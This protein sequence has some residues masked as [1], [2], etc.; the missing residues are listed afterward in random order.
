M[1]RK[2][3]QIGDP[4]LLKKSKD[5]DPKDLL[6][7]E[8]QDLIKD[9]LDTC[10]SEKEGTAG[11]SAVQIG[12]LKRVF[13]ARRVDLEMDADSDDPIWEVMINPEIFV[14]NEKPVEMWEGC[15]SIGKGDE[16]LFGPVSRPKQIEVKYLDEKGNSKSLVAKDY[17]AHVVLHEYD[18]L[19]GTLFLSYIDNPENIWKS[20]E[21]D[22]YLDE[23]DHYPPVL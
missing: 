10:D 20:G 1:V 23:H 22:G 13:I 5:I 8:T 7:R 9:L 21:L 3:L 2:I 4:I 17:M 11:L 12:V 6:S 18:H 16:R 19:E 15:L 14:L